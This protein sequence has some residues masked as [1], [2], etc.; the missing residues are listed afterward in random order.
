MKELAGQTI[1]V[2]GAS[3]GIGAAIVEQLASESAKVVIQ[4][5]RDEDAARRLHDR[6]NGAGW[7]LQADLSDP[8]GSTDLWKR[9]TLVAGRIHSLVNNAG[10]RTEISIDADLDQWQAAWKREFQVDF[11]QLSIC[12]E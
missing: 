3:G 9:A 4:Y 1:L 8:S 2:T 6:I 12:A 11:L 7:I 5:G 10:I